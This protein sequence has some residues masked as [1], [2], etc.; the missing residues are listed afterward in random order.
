[1][2]RIMSPQIH[3]KCHDIAIGPLHDA[4]RTMTFH[5]NTATFAW[6]FAIVFMLMLPAMT[7][8]VARDGPP[9]GHSLPVIAAVMGF[10]WLGGLGLSAYAMTKCCLRVTVL[11]DGALSIAW[12]YPFRTR[13]RIVALASVGSAEVLQAEDSEGSPYF[14]TRV[15]LADG[16]R[17]DLAEGHSRERCVS[18]AEAFNACLRRHT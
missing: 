18:K 6:G 10:I 9:E 3:G 15:S 17:I 5:N 16:S 12:R 7:Y 11:V 2:G 14:Y 8:V 1:M 4:T 13:R